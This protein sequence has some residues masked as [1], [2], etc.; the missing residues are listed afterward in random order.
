MILFLRRISQPGMVKATCDTCHALRDLPAT[1]VTV[2]VGL[3]ADTFSFAFRCPA[4][5][6]INA[7]PCDHEITADLANAGA[8]EWLCRR[9]VERFTGP[10]PATPI[11]EETI[12]EAVAW[13]AS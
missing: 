8:V 12:A 13:L 3:D 9:P 4:C 10:A 7:G 5:G 1:G 11:T 2:L 6:T